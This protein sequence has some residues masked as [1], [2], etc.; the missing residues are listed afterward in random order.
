[1]LLEFDPL[2]L[3]ATLGEEALR[4][5]PLELLP[6]HSFSIFPDSVMFPLG[7]FEEVFVSRFRVPVVVNDLL[8]HGSRRARPVVAWRAM[9]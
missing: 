9:G 2:L 1:L 7:S 6:V 8:E 4:L 5:L 3:L